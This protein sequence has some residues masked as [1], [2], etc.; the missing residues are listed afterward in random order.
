MQM[1]S[2]VFVV[3]I[4][5]QMPCHGNDFEVALKAVLDEEER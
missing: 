4:S 5:E 2:T 3:T 1:Q